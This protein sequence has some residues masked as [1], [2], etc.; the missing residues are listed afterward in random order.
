MPNCGACYGEKTEDCPDDCLTS[1]VRYIE[2]EEN[3]K[4]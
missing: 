4:L 2:D 3:G 1:H